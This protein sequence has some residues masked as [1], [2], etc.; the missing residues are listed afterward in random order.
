MNEPFVARERE[1][2]ELQRCLESHRSEF[3][4][5]YGRRR[6]GKT[7]LIENFFKDRYAFKFVGTRGAKTRVQLANFAQVLSQN[8]GEERRQLRDWADAFYALQRYL[9]H[10]PA[11]GKKVVFFDEMPWIDT[12]RSDFVRSLEYFWN[13]WA[14]SQR[15]ILFIATGS[16]T[17]WMTEKL[18]ANKG[19]L[20]GRI[21]RRLHVAPF[22]LGE[23]EN[24]L[25]QL[26]CKWDRLQ[27]LQSYMLLGG[28]PFY[29]SLIEPQDS[30]AQNIDNLFFH[31]DGALRTEFNELY[32]ALFKNADL[33]LAVAKLLCNHKEG[34][35][36]KEIAKGIGC[37]GGKLT[38]VLKNMERCDFLERWNQYGNTKRGSLYRMVDF[39]TK[40]YYTFVEN[41]NFK[42]SRWWSNNMRE[43][44]VSSWM[45]HT[46]E[47]VCMQH[48]Q[49]IKERLHIDT[50]GTAISS[51]R[52]TADRTSGQEGAQI[53]MIIERADRIIHLCEMKYSISQYTLTDKY[54]ETVRN[55]AAIFQA[56]TATTKA[57]VHTFVTTFGVKDGKHKSIVHSEVTMDDL[58]TQTAYTQ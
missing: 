33:Y 24:Y 36:H 26:D 18:V 10:L 6:V 37:D 45:G 32:H 2:A 21:T 15:D 46:F 4:V 19:G 27:I 55:R 54:E 42:D 41:N 12:Q 14:V 51:W 34:L 11:D 43:P 50:I 7:Y 56:A 8:S 29:Y 9:E 39:F 38:V 1:C 57:V 23:V 44:S 16:A 47:L 5:V 58:F 20:H 22:T 31:E 40:F 30:L 13:S 49:Q 28:V 53:D 35:T 17:S 25:R 52:Q 3:V 48:H